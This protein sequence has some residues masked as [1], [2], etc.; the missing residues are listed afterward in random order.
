MI[1]DKKRIYQEIDKAIENE[2]KY[3]GM[4]YEQGVEDALK[5]VLLGEE[6]ETLFED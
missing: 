6:N 5:W 3:Q 1:T 4:S 2:G